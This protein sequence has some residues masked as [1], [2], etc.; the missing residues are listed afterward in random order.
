MKR[1]GHESSP[2]PEAS[3]PSSVSGVRAGAGAEGSTLD[4]V[5][6]RARGQEVGKD[7][8]ERMEW[9]A[10]SLPQSDRTVGWV[11]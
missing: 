4:P 5:T 3:K 1:E 9:S 10:E 6:G 8:A 11:T 2:G 7:N